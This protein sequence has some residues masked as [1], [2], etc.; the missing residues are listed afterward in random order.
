MKKAVITGVAGL[1]GSHAASKY[2]EEGYR[3]IGIDNLIGGR[4]ENV[5]N[6]VEY[7]NLDLTSR[8]FI[9]NPLWVNTDIV[10]HAAALAHEGYSV[11]SPA[12]I[13]ESNIQA[14]VNVAT[15]A[16]KHK[17]KRLVYLSSM[18]RYGD[19]GGELFTEEMVPQP[20]TPYG[21]AKLA[22]EGLLKNICDYHGVEWTIIVP[23]NVIGIGQK[24]DD[25]YRNVA[26]IFAN[27]LLQGKNPIIYGD[28]SQERSFTFVQDVV[29]P[30]YLA[31]VSDAAVGEIFNVGPD[32]HSTTILELGRIIASYYGLTYAPEFWTSRPKETQVA[33][34][35]S[36][37]AR[38]IL[39][40]NPRQNMEEGLFQMLD[41]IKEKGPREFEYHIP[42]EIE[43]ENTPKTWSQKTM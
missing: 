12:I 3:V 24:Y 11:F 40:F 32:S 16:A 43:T 5:P 6:G 19:S 20:K 4:L 42:L 37:K 38:R 18:S 15:A 7:I 35:S 36:D 29:D 25:P 26:G 33:L 28:G 1:I 2:L 30:L 9:D 21:L 14:T 13:T 8:E 23:H 17:A 10:V 41:W 34:C 31:S 27:R 22:A 39:A